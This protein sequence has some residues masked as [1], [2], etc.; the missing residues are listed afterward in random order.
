MTLT[1]VRRDELEGALSTYSLLHTPEFNLA[2]GQFVVRDGAEAEEVFYQPAGGEEIRLSAEAFRQTAQ[3]ALVPGTLVDKTPPS[4]ILPIVRYHA[5]GLTEERQRR[6]WVYREVGGQPVAQALVKA[7]APSVDALGILSAIESVFDPQHGQLN[8]DLVQ[9]T[10]MTIQAS[11]IGA[12][13]TPLA[14]GDLHSAGLTFYISLDGS[15]PHSLQAYVRRMVCTNGMIS[16]YVIEKASRAHPPANLVDWFREQAQILMPRVDE[17]YG[18]I[19]ASDTEPLHG[20]L[21]DI[22]GNVF[23]DLA[24]PTVAREPIMDELLR[25]GIQSTYD[26]IQA[27]T[28]VGTHNEGVALAGRATHLLN[29]GGDLA[30]NPR[31]CPT[32]NHRLN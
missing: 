22:V 20:E 19:N 28:Y 5:G 3:T 13:Q 9:V 15:T 29:I 31:H 4:V 17:V 8:Y 25:T 11:V 14:R 16:P 32:C 30:H 1:N 10:D 12:L 26:I 24:V 27:V 6:K 2:E 21:Q 18:F 7:N 23:N